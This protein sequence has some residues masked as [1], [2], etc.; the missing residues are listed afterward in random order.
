M[1]SP[2][3]GMDSYLEDPSLW[4]GFHHSPSL[5]KSMVDWLATKLPAVGGHL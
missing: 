5:R 2:F 1:P 3:P 4:R